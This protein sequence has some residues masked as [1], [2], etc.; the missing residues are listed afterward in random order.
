MREFIEV[1]REFIEILRESIAITR[2]FM[3]W[4]TPNINSHCQPHPALEEREFNQNHKNTLRGYHERIYGNH[5]E[6]S[7]QCQQSRLHPRWPCRGII[8]GNHK[9]IH[10]IHKR[11]YGT[12][13]NVN[14]HCRPHP[15]CPCRGR[16]YGETGAGLCSAGA[17][18]P[19]IHAMIIDQGIENR[20]LC[21]TVAFLRVDIFSYFVCIFSYFVC[22]G[23]V[24]LLTINDMLSYKY[25]LSNRDNYSD[26]HKVRFP[27]RTCLLLPTGF[28]LLGPAIALIRHRNVLL[29]L[30]IRNVKQ[31]HL[32]Y[33]AHGFSLKLSMQDQVRVYY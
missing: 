22:P 5:K 12:T 8:N 4:Q 7:S 33:S 19:P 14:S 25:D 28:F 9:R 11:I 6:S 32:Q 16:I 20:I 17:P 24:Q 21:R 10:H 27:C 29:I 3:V 26:R 31:R 2:E 23:V 15:R 18:S 30:Q 13:P 1:T